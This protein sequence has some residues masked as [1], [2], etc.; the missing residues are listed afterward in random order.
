MPVTDV[1]AH[2]RHPGAHTPASDRPRRSS[3]APTISAQARR[4]QLLA[5]ASPDRVR[6]A[7][8]SGHGTAQAG[9]GAAWV[10]TYLHLIKF[11]TLNMDSFLYVSHTQRK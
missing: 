8:P 4:E 2:C 9:M 6:K 10:Y 11:Y 1:R 7:T 5:S 3:G